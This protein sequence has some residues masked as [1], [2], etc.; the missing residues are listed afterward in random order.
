VIDGLIPHVAYRDSGVPWL[1]TLP[2]GWEAV[3]VRRVCRV[4]AGATPS[5]ATPDYWLDGTIPWLASGDVNARRITGASQFITDAGFAASSTK[6]IRPGSLVVALAGQ[7]KTK[8]M[9][10]TVEFPATCNQSLGVLE[11]DPKRSDYR[12]LAYYLETRYFDLRGLVGDGIRDGLNLDH[13]KAIPTPLPPLEEQLAIVRFLDHADRRIRRYIAARRKL[14]A[15]L[16]EQKQAVIHRAVTRG[17]DP[18][19]CLRPSG[20][21]WLGAVPKHWEVRRAKLL[22]R[23][24]DI[25]STAGT[26]TLLSL[27]MYQGLVP[28]IDV[29][30][31]PITAQALVGFKK[32]APGQLVMNRMRAAISMFGIARQPGLVSPDYA[33]FEALGSVNS[34]Y[35]L[36]LFKTRAVGTIF[37]LESKGLGTG[38]SGFMRLYTDRFGT[39]KLP[40]PPR[41]EQDL[42]VRGLAAETQE[43]DRTE[44]RVNREIS[45]LGEYRTRLISDVVTGKLDVREA[46][47][48]LPDEVDEPE[49]LA[50]ADAL[51][52]GDEPEDEI[53]LGDAAGEVAG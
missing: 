36:R 49:L 30:T 33:V 29:S 28:H 31:V 16:N 20:V 34:E 13:L 26:E 25:R 8:G 37:R 2:V 9:V 42:I 46:V 21:E 7:G 14:I 15:L 23:E 38:S 6:W 47:A 4:F 27:R 41:E 51:A 43:I 5:R 32:V 22:F 50:D 52:D 12:F 11:P 18:N 35:Y 10:A 48:R 1:G 53:D 24:V 45:F 44:D 40:V 19:V 17:S 39:I 3:S